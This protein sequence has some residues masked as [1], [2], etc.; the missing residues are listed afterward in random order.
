MLKSDGHRGSIA[1]ALQAQA[2][3]WRAR[4]CATRRPD[5]AH[6]ESATRQSGALSITTMWS[7]P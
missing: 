5:N 1:L 3:A 6:E 4:A 2:D 7:L